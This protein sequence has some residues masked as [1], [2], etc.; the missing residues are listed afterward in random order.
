VYHLREYTVGISKAFASLNDAG[1]ISMI[2][3][4]IKAKI[5]ATSAL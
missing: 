5:D 1:T 2:G 4:R 3:A